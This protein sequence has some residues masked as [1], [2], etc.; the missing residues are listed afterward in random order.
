MA[1]DA[2][3]MLSVALML[4][5]DNHGCGRGQGLIIGAR[6][7]LSDPSKGVKAMDELAE[8]KIYPQVPA[9]GSVG[10]SPRVRGSR[11]SIY[12]QYRMRRSI[13]AGAGEPAAAT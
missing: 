2:T 3:R 12:G 13:P 8:L 1:S 5:A 10:P 11:E 9:Q 6:V 7:F 4:L